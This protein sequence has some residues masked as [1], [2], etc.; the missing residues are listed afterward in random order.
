MM[1][2]DVTGRIASARIGNESRTDSSAGANGIRPYAVAFLLVAAALVITLPMQ[3]FFLHPF[4][5]L[6]F[7]AVMASAW[8]GGTLAGLFAVLIATLAVD[9]FLISPFY[10]FA[11]N[12]T[13]VA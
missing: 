10:S 9:Y 13:E 11:I 6:F 12:T 4:V 5:V 1:A 7:L 3:R 2:E 8:V